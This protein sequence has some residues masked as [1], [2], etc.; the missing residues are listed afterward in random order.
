MKP[1]AKKTSTIAESI[2]RF[3][4][5]LTPPKHMVSKCAASSSPWAARMKAIFQPIKSPIAVTEKLV[6]IG[7][8]HIGIADTIGVGTPIMVQK[9]LDAA[10]RYI[11]IDNISGH[12]H[13][14]WSSA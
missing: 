8:E 11:D 13:D 7:A 5:W 9:A 12:F 1:L 4:P 10:L 2:E 14:T 6:A 3:A